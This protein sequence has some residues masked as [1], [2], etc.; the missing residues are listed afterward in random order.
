MD[1][2]PTGQPVQL[3]GINIYRIANHQIVANHEQVNA[4]EVVQQL[5]SAVAAGT[6]EEPASGL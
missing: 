4:A 2:P 3:T 6:A 5:R 1:L